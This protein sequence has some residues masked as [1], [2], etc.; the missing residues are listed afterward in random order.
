LANP[1]NNADLS[2]FQDLT[3]L[4]HRL[5]LIAND[6]ITRGCAGKILAVVT[7]AAYLQ[8][9]DGEILW[10]ARTSVPLHT[11]G[12]QCAFDERRL[13]VGMRF[14]AR[15]AILQIG[16]DVTIDLRAAR[17][18][19]PRVITNIVPREIMVARSRPEGF[20]KTLRVYE[21]VARACCAQ[22]IVAMAEECKELIGLGA[23]LTP[24]GDDF[25]GGVL[26]A[27]HHLRQ[28]YAL[29]WDTQPIDDLLRWARTQTNIISYTILRDHARGVSVEPLHDLLFALLARDASDNVAECAARVTRLGNSTGAEILAGVL[30]G[31]RLIE[32]IEK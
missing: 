23:G 14:I 5:G 12:V 9:D 4:S 1:S 10:L 7:N 27:A 21:A 20:L 32:G 3:S 29:T 28:A 25:V 19:Q 18:W 22:D 26:F 16:E 15:E 17:L 31:L 11:R 13:R 8:T 2:G 30:T 6:L 24:A